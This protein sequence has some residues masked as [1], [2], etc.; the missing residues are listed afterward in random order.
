MSTNTLVDHI[1]CQDVMLKYAKGVDERDMAL[2]RSC[3]AQDAVVIFDGTTYPSVQAWFGFVDDALDGFGATQHML[4]P[5]LID[6]DAD[7]AHCRTDVQALHYLKDAPDTTLTL[8]GTYETDMRRMD[9]VWKIT[10]HEVVVRG[11]R[12]QSG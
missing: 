1:A 3:F 4:G 10:R 11:T 12:R 2:Y 8:W 6:I 7:T 5:S 9:G